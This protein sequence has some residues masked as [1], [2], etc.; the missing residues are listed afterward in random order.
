MLS[1]GNFVSLECFAN[2]TGISYAVVRQF[3]SVEEIKLGLLKETSFA[4]KFTLSGLGDLR[5]IKVDNL[6]FKTIVYPN[7][8]ILD[9]SIIKEGFE[10]N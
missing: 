8:N 6:K 4:Y 10:H 7:G 1:N 9:V 2:R 3:E 5:L